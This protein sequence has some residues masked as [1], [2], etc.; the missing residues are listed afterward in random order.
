MCEW[1]IVKGIEMNWSLSN[2]RLRLQDILIGSALHGVHRSWR[3][4]HISDI[5][6]WAMVAHL[7]LSRS[8]SIIIFVFSTKFCIT[9]VSISQ[10][11][12]LV[13][14]RNENNPYAKYCG[15]NKLHYRERESRK[16]VVHWKIL[17]L[18]IESECTFDSVPFTGIISTIGDSN[19]LDHK[20]VRI[21]SFLY[22]V[23]I[24]HKFVWIETSC[25]LIS[26]HIKPTN[27][28]F[29]IFHCTNYSKSF[30]DSGDSID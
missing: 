10:T 2:Q 6:K 15:K 25:D 8:V 23:F 9:F 1:R 18:D 14:R 19:I 28:V 29:A 4:K 12:S 5:V 13:P 17:T 26:F 24:H 30:T 22:I 16:L 3:R 11:R 21:P 7:R 27:K 20:R